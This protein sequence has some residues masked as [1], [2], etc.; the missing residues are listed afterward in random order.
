MTTAQ[1][2]GLGNPANANQRQKKIM[3]SSTG[4]ARQNST[5]TADTPRTSGF[6]R[7]RPTPNTRPNRTA[8]TTASTVAL[9]V[10]HR[11][12]R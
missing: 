7:S 1:Y 11:P 8:P 4:T 5:I 3:S 9:T 2:E 6:G 12:G 10:I